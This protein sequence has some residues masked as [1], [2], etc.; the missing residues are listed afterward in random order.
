MGGGSF[1]AEAFTT[2]EFY[3]SIYFGDTIGE[4]DFPKWLSRATDKLHYLTYGNITDETRAEYDAQIQK[5]T[6]ALM[7]M[8]YQIDA[9]TKRAT[10]KDET[11]MKSRSSGSESYTFGDKD[12]AVTKVLADKSAQDRLMQDVI[13]EYLADTGLMYAGV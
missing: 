6:C 4:A 7:D 8:M 1:L 2:Y 12:T 9:E 5:A 13:A 10:A 3:T 11:N